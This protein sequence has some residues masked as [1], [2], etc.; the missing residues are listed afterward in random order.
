MQKKISRSANSGVQGVSPEVISNDNHLPPTA[1]KPTTSKP[2]I[3]PKVLASPKKSAPQ[4]SF[5]KKKAGAGLPPVAERAVSEPILTSS[6]ALESLTQ[7]AASEPEAL[8]PVKIPATKPSP[9]FFDVKFALSLVAIVVCVNVLLAMLVKTDA[10]P[11]SPVIAAAPVSVQTSE[12]L[13]Q[14]VSGDTASGSI[15]HN[16]DPLDLLSP[17]AGSGIVAV[18]GPSQTTTAPSATPSTPAPAPL[19]EAKPLELGVTAVDTDT[20]KPPRDLM[21]IIGQY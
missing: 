3:M 16:Q 18:T 9:V 15:V 4:V 8:D 14:R 10:T 12:P 17:S 13:A 21:S 5:G 19:P 6:P 1:E 11:S 2:A 20:R 7:N